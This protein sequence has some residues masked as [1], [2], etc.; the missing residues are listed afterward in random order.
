MQYVENALQN[1]IARVKAV[2]QDYSR[3]PKGIGRFAANHIKGDLAKAENALASG[4]EN[5]MIDHHQ[6]LSAYRF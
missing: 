4:N 2:A 5:A 1:E 6:K 3:Q